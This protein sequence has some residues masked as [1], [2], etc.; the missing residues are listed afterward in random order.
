MQAFYLILV[1]FFLSLNLRPAITS[2]GPLL[3]VI[4]T[5][6]GMSGVTAS[7]LTTLPVF[8]MGVFALVSIKLSN[9]LGTEKSLMVAMFLIF[10]A[11]V[12]RV[13]LNSSWLLI[14]TALVSGIGIGIAGPLIS[15]F[16]KKYFPDKLSITSVYSV[17]MV[18]GASFATSFSIP[19]FHAFQESWQWSLSIWSVFAFIALVLLAPLLASRNKEA[20]TMSLPSLKVQN[21]RVYLFTVLFGFVATIFYSITAWLAPYVQSMGMSGSQSGLVLTLFTAVQI[22]FSFLLP[23][24]VS[25]T[26][27]RKQWLL[28]CILAEFVGVFFLIAVFA[29][30]VAAV[31]LGFGAGG[32]FPLA[33]LIPI[34]EASNINEATSWSAQM[35]FGGF[36]VASMG[37]FIFG[38]ALDMFNSFVPAF[39]LIMV[40]LCVMTFTVIKLEKKQ[41]KEMPQ[42]QIS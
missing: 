15:G 23:L 19:F 16:I 7:L 32:L 28:I 11:T 25:R 21:K 22:P 12:S 34:D 41:N 3:D 26:G 10:L 27:K 4:Q 37:P 17:A 40:I 6:L 35:Q 20:K 36:I 42:K 33:L 2:V 30:W 8:C 14:V 9:K 24:L 18:I 39:L 1:V 38:L 5:D 31:C 29:P 13:F